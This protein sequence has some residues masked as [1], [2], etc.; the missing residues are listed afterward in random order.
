MSIPKEVADR[1]HRWGDRDDLYSDFV[2]RFLTAYDQDGF[3]WGERDFYD[4]ET[5]KTYRT[6][7]KLEIDEVD[8]PDDDSCPEC[9]EG[10]VDALDSPDEL[11]CDV[12]GFRRRGE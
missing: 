7:L 3:A 11:V 4:P 9:G 2:D 6:Q 10:L 12:C 5:R 8:P 1:L